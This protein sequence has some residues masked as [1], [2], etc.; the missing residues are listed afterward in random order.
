MPHF[1]NVFV[2]W[3]LFL[4]ALLYT[5]I[6]SLNMFPEDLDKYICDTGYWFLSGDTITNNY[7]SVV[8]DTNERNQHFYAFSFTTKH[9]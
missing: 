3:V 6:V 5:C 7:L 9:K 4:S 1:K 8:A 2:L